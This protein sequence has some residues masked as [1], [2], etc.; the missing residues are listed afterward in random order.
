[1]VGQDVFGGKMRVPISLLWRGCSWVSNAYMAGYVGWWI[2]KKVK[3]NEEP[4]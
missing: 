2:Y 4:K 3:K 1:M